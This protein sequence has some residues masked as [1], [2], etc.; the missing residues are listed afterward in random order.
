MEN[1]CIISNW[2][3]TTKDG[4]K[5]DGNEFAHRATYEKKYGKVSRHLQVCHS[6]D[7]AAC[8]NIE[9]LWLGTALENAQDKVK[10]DRQPKGEKIHCAKLTVEQVKV[11]KY[12]LLQGDKLQDLATDFKVSFGLIGHIKYGIKWKHV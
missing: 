7:N 12:R 10:K 11:I 1:N 6:C 2:P 5:T 8:V 9:H 3:Y 4:Y